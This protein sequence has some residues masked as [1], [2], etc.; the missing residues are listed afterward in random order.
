MVQFPPPLTLPQADIQRCSMLAMP[1][2][3]SLSIQFF[4]ALAA[5]QL[6]TALDTLPVLFL[7]CFTTSAVL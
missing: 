2:A 6:D 1:W 7:L 3:A 4:S 5:P